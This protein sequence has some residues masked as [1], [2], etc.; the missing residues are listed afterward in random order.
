M[1]E[2]LQAVNNN[3]YVECMKWRFVMDSD[4]H[5]YSLGLF[6]LR[7]A[8]TSLE[9]IHYLEIW[10]NIGKIDW[11]GALVKSVSGLEFFTWL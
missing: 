10:L 3:D 6:C 5:N 1:H 8:W 7:N 2:I 4:P 11:K 9:S